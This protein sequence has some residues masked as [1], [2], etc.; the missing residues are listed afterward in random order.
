MGFRPAKSGMIGS[1]QRTAHPYSGTFK[2]D[3]ASPSLFVNCTKAN[4]L[5]RTCKTESLIWCR[6]M[7]EAKYKP[8]SSWPFA[9]ETV[10]PL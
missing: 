5:V 6:V 10:S 3:Q 1:S 2:S 9:Q 8:T 7:E 4:M